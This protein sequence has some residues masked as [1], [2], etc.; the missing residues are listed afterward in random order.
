MF[1]KKENDILEYANSTEQNVP[2]PASTVSAA[3]G[4]LTPEDDSHNR[5]YLSATTSD[6]ARVSQCDP[7]TCR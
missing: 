3:V 2:L 4:C 1:P 5:K 6:V 7:S